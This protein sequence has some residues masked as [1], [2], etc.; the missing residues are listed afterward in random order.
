M[1]PTLLVSMWPWTEILLT[2]VL[3]RAGTAGYHCNPTSEVTK[4]VRPTPEWGHAGLCQQLPGASHT[5]QA[6]AHATGV[7]G[8]Q[9][10]S[11]PSCPGESQDLVVR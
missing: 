7:M 9:V 4:Y 2:S 1:H 3:W 8:R 10:T 5:W 11:C 6:V